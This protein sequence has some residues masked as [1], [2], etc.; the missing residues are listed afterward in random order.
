MTISTSPITIDSP[1]HTKVPSS[2]TKPPMKASSPHN[3][4]NHHRNP[5][6]LSSPK[7][8]SKH[9]IKQR[10]IKRNYSPSRSN[11]FMTQQQQPSFH[12]QNNNML[13]NN[14]NRMNV[15]PSRSEQDFFK[16]PQPAKTFNAGFTAREYE[17]PMHN[18]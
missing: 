6:I 14:Q 15:Q 16:P 17:R 5:K 4:S 7:T 9:Y 10:N 3:R 12:N 13:A 11:N 8:N 1:K 18:Q 2:T